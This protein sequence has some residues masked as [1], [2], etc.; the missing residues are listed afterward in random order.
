MDKI[1]W[2]QK[3]SVNVKEIDGQHKKLIGLLNDVIRIK[4]EKLKFDAT[5][6]VLSE[7]ANYMDYHFSTEE[8]YMLKF[9]YPEYKL[10]RDQHV[11][12]ARKTIGFLKK[13]REGSQTITDEIICFIKDWLLNHILNHDAKYGPFFNK[14]GLF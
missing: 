6:D 13:F 7:L 1:Q 4:E 3:F 12:F 8:R 2:N 5:G 14:N 9:S 11:E 10:H